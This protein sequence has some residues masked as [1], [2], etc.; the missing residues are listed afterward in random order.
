MVIGADQSEG[1]TPDRCV[2][3]IARSLARSG[4]EMRLAIVPRLAGAPI[5]RDGN[6]IAL[7]A[8][9]HRARETLLGEQQDDGGDT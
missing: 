8:K 2:I 9:A 1:Q 7:I 6:L 4:H 3:P 5:V